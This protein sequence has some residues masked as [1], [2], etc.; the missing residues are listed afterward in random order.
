MAAPQ[1]EMFLISNSE[2]L[3][4]ES[5]LTQLSNNVSLL[6]MKLAAADKALV[7]ADENLL[8]ANQLINQMQI[9]LEKANRSFGQYAKEAQLAIKKE[10]DARK[11]ERLLWIG[12][13]LAAKYL[14]G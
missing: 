11:R 10:Q 6:E 4:L 3:K 7:K 14:S 5:N 13:I 8:K 1:E 12:G 9:S 2:L